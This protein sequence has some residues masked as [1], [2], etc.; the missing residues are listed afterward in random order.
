MYRVIVEAGFFA[1]HRVRSRDGVLEP[2]H[3]H[4]WAVRAHFARAEL[5]DV[6]MVIDFDR[7]R[8]SLQAVMAQLHGTDLNRLEALAGLNP[9]AEVLA[10]YIF[11]RMVEQGLSILRRV[12]VTEAEACV[13]IYEPARSS[14]NPD[15]G[16]GLPD[17]VTR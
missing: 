5:D 2:Q 3:G 1:V 10:R 8:S 12:E 9:T 6:G 16:C 17:G 13:A 7:A 4:N 15:K 14:T 11:D